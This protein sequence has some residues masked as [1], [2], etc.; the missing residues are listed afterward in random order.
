MSGKKKYIYIYLPGGSVVKNLPAMQETRVWSLDQEDPLEKEMATQSSILAW[1]IP[2]TV[3]LCG[4]QFMGLQRV[5]HDF[6]TQQQQQNIYMYIFFFQKGHTL[7]EGSREECVP[8][9][10]VSNAFHDSQPHDSNLYLCCH[11]T[12][13]PL[14]LWVFLWPF[15]Y[16]YIS[17]SGLGALPT[18]PPWSIL[19]VTTS[20]MT[21]LP[22]KFTFWG[23]RG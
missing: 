23:T 1:E 13:F 4:L 8:C 22:N 11:M 2:W 21:W 6:L 3:E 12:F 14:C 18:T 5:K 19:I 7:F 10:S 17:P 9:L 20:A 16:K 15:F